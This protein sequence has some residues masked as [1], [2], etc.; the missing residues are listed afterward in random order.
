MWR[1]EN[2]FSEALKHDTILE[3]VFMQLGNLSVIRNKNNKFD[4]FKENNQPFDELMKILTEKLEKN[5]VVIQHYIDILIKWGLVKY[6]VNN[7]EGLDLNNGSDDKDEERLKFFKSKGFPVKDCNIV[8]TNRSISMG[9]TGISLYREIILDKEYE[10][11]TAEV[12]KVLKESLTSGVN[13]ILAPYKTEIETLKGE[14][15]KKIEQVNRELDNGI[16]KN[17]Q[18]LSIFAGMISLL[19]ANIMGIKEFA[20]IG[21]MGLATINV[22]VVIALF[23]LLIFLK[24]IVIEEKI[25]KRQFWGCIAIMFVLSIPIILMKLV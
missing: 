1:D 17:I 12:G 24:W 7:E 5:D 13:E 14:L 21:A 4:F 18:V 22:S 8:L 10:E 9:C 20:A 11:S 16:I 15:E 25:E 2:Y 23:S 6:V 3:A 19:F